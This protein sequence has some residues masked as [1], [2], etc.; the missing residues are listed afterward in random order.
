MDLFSGGFFPP[1][2]FRIWPIVARVAIGSTATVAQRS[3]TRRYDEGEVKVKTTRPLREG[4]NISV[5]DLRALHD[6]AEGLCAR[7]SI[8]GSK[9]SR[10][11]SHP[12][13]VPCRLRPIVLNRMLGLGRAGGRNADVQAAIDLYRGA[14]FER[15]SGSPI[16]AIHD[17][18][19]R[20]EAAGL[21]RAQ[22]WQS[23]RRGRRRVPEVERARYDPDIGP[24]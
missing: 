14:A 21:E 5:P 2:L 16:R 10:T 11:V 7:R 17:R 3:H 15:S 6:A 18:S 24:A 19:R 13:R 9:Q 4:E 23:S 8:S 20:C 1:R 22:G 12:S